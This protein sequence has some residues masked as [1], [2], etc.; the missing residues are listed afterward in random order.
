MFYV[1][2]VSCNVNVSVVVDGLRAGPSERF[3]LCSSG[4]MFYVSVVADGLRAGPSECFTLRSFCVTLC[5][6]C[7]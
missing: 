1:T 5:F 6:C 3:T 7:S 4:V 2:F